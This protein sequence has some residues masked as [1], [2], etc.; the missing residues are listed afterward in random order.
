MGRRHFLGLCAGLSAAAVLGGCDRAREPLRIASHVWPGYEPMFLARNRGWLEPERVALLETPSASVSMA[1]L[2]S[3]E[4]HGA[5]LTLDEVLRVRSEGVDLRVVLVFNISAG[6]DMVVARRDI[7]SLGE[8]RG[9][10]IGAEDSALGA[11]MLHHLLAHAGLERGDVEVASLAINDQEAA[12]REGRVDALVT[13]EPLAGRL[14][15]ED[16]RLLFDSR[17]LPD[18]IFDVL[19]VRSES[20]DSHARAIRHLSASHFRALEYIRRNPV[21]AGYRMAERLGVPGEEAMDTFRGLVL[22]DYRANRR[23][24]AGDGSRV[25]GAAR[26]IAEVMSAAGIAVDGGIDGELIRDRFLAPGA[27]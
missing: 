27:G 8:L 4:V 26:E 11:L 12:W 24:L 23:L 10:R 21:D 15:R 7:T 1:R 5:A 16:A 20:C 9:R 2:A 18:T 6:A 13:F 3:G 14:L 17:R 22:P 25:M 19:A